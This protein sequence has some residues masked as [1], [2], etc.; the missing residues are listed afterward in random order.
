MSVC[1]L[2]LKKSL[3]QKIWVPQ[4]NYLEEAGH[5]DIEVLVN[6]YF[7][8]MMIQVDL[9]QDWSSEAVSDLTL[10]NTSLPFFKPSRTVPSF[11]Y[12]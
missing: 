1:L 2:E 4:D 3:Y 11:L 5:F 8:Q 9:I 6:I 7:S 10:E 12:L